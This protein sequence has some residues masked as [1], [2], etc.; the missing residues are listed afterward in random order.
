M[1]TDFKV[2]PPR[3]KGLKVKVIPLPNMDVVQGLKVDITHKNG[4]GEGVKT[5]YYPLVSSPD[6]TLSRGETVW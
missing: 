4:S 1:T 6:P 3:T 5:G 2:I